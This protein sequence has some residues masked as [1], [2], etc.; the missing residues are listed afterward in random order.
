MPKKAI[1]LGADSVLMARM[2]IFFANSNTFRLA[3]S[4]GGSFTTPMLTN[5]MP[6]AAT[7]I[8]QDLKVRLA[9][10]TLVAE[11]TVEIKSVAREAGDRTKIAVWSKND[12]VDCVGA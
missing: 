8:P 10:T 12:K 1:E 2:P 5:L 7:D 6:L 11:G 4:S 9:D 3:A